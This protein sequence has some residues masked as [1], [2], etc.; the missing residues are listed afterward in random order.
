MLEIKD[1]IVT[2][3][4][5][6][7]LHAY[8]QDTYISKDNNIFTLIELDAVNLQYNP[9]DFTSFILEVSNNSETK[10]IM[11]TDTTINNSTF[12]IK[13]KT[14]L[15]D[16]DGDMILYE[17][18]FY[19]ENDKYTVKPML[20]KISLLTGVKTTSSFSYNRLYGVKII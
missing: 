20:T 12:E 16:G 5:L 4:S 6:A 3:E 11:L 15:L 18:Y 10:Q 14:F 7:I 19:L 1:K 9:K 17:V 13:A 8:N 2:V